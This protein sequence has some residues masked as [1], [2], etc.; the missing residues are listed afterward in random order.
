MEIIVFYKDDSIIMC[1]AY[2]RMYL[3]PDCTIGSVLCLIV[4]QYVLHSFLL[5]AICIY[6][7]KKGII[8]GF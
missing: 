6:T 7:S 3:V 4:T 8:G 1:L 5:F 2:G